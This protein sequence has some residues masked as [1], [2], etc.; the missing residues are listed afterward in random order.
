MN[1]RLPRL[2]EWEYAA[3]GAS[4]SKG[5][6]HSGSN[7]ADDVAWYSENSDETTHP[8][9]TKLPNKIEIYDM[10]VNVS[11]Y[12]MYTRVYD[13]YY[14]Y[15]Y[16]CI[17]GGSYDNVASISSSEFQIDKIYN[18]LANKPTPSKYQYTY[19]GLRIAVDDIE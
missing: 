4:A 14:S 6:T 15:H 16:Y 13:N 17:S 8:V 1:Y 2:N 11:E 7:N 3:K 18:Q 10:I 12:L 5:Y 19:L 9:K